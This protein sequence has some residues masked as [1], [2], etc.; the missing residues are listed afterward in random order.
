MDW[1]CQDLICPISSGFTPKTGTF[2]ALGV[3][4]QGGLRALGDYLY[5]MIGAPCVV[6][7]ENRSVDRKYM[8]N[9]EY[10]FTEATERAAWE[11]MKSSC[12]VSIASSFEES[13]KVYLVHFSSDA[14]MACYRQG[15]SVVKE[16][17]G[18]NQQLA[19]LGGA[20]TGLQAE[21]QAIMQENRSTVAEAATGWP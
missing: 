9:I 12:V 1:R 13:E 2:V 19:I 10:P 5:L 18:G 14:T 7:F 11:L 4:G 16:V 21:M 17:G 8:V 20:V 6:R 3:E 15:S